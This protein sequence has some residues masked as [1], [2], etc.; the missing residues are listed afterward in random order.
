MRGVDVLIHLV[1]A[2]HSWSHLAQPACR[3]HALP[4]FAHGSESEMP[5]FGGLMGFG[6]GYRDCVILL[7]PWTAISL[8]ARAKLRARRHSK[9]NRPYTTIV[10][11]RER[12]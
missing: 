1:S 7:R 12:G 4:V 3:K 11:R 2:F 10:Y 9:D 6:G 5:G 8:G